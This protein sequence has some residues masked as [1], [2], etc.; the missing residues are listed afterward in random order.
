MKKITLINLDTTVLKEYNAFAEANTN[1]NMHSYVNMKYDINAAIAFGKFYFPEF[2]EIK[3]CIILKERFNN[4]IFEEWYNEFV[5]DVSKI[6]KM[7]NLYE[8]GDFFHINTSL[9]DMKQIIQFGHILKKSYEI[10][11]KLLFPN[12]EFEVNFFEENETQYITFFQK[13]E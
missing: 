12:R 10:N 8:V 4:S 1:W 3:N 5:G 11:L 13:E 9:A 2:I 6:E 7:C